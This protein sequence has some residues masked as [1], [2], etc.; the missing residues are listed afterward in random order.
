V[1]SVWVLMYGPHAPMVRLCARLL[2]VTLVLLLPRSLARAQESDY[3]ALTTA[4]VEE[5]SL[6]HYEEARALFAKAHALNPN[7][8]TLWGMGTAA[9]EARQYAD[10][11]RLLQ[12]AMVDSRKPLTSSQRNQAEPLLKRA[13]DFVVRVRFDVVP[14][15]A[16][17]SVDGT[18]VAADVDGI[19]MVDAGSHQV[20]ASA[21]GYREVVRV[22]RWAAGDV[23]LEIRL[24]PNPLPTAPQPA[25]A[26]QTPAPPQTAASSAP[27]QGK[28]SFKVLKWV[29]LGA[30]AASLGVAL[31]G[32]GLRQREAAK[33][34]DD[35]KCPP[36]KDQSCPATKDAVQ[37]WH[38][39]G[40]A[41]GVAAGAM[42]VLTLVFFVLDR[43]AAKDAAHS[44]LG[45]Q[46]WARSTGLSCTYRF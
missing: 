4:A 34:N 20:I 6:G 18:A 31:A 22:V 44:K 8:R 15:D 17:L 42:A 40:L 38:T 27:L 7:A 11:I 26:E 12:Q 9:F 41:S 24:E 16:Q 5:H 35:I 45:C 43:R 46:P 2:I 32:Y 36:D 3:K 25:L 23:A 33:W 37:K 28:R 29:A 13:A 10:A 30:T 1:A 14:T 19:V 21:P 39:M